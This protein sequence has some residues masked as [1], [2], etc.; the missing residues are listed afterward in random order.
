M[1]MAAR[2]YEE[3]NG[4]SGQAQCEIAKGHLS[5]PR[6]INIDVSVFIWCEV[7]DIYA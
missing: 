7:V 4:K 1:R 6:Y 5:A 2:K 3:I